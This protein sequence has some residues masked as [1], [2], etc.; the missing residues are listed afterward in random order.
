[1]RSDT[2]NWDPKMHDEST[3]SRERIRWERESGR[4]GRSEDFFRLQEVERGHARRVKSRNE[5][6]EA[7]TQSPEVYHKA[8][9]EN[10]R[11]EIRRFERQIEQ[12]KTKGGYD[13]KLGSVSYIRSTQLAPAK[14]RLDWHLAKVEKIRRQKRRSQLRK[15]RQ[16]YEARHP[17]RANRFL[18][19]KESA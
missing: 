2:S 11:K 3:P 17:E 15:A 9:V 16:A 6:W 5:F 7:K 1:M 13:P 10:A 19:L 8:G 12:V 4:R 14:G 18:K